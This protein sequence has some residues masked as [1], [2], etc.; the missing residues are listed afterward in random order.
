MFQSIFCLTMALFFLAGCQ[1]KPEK[2][3]GPPGTT[4][5]R[6]GE[7][8][9]DNAA[10]KPA[11][12]AARGAVGKP[13]AVKIEVEV[14][15][16]LDGK[17]EA[18]AKVAA[19]GNELGKTDEKGYLL[20][21]LQKRP[22][23]EIEIVV[24]KEAPGL[25]VTPWK[26]SFV[27]KIPTGPQA[28]RYSFKAALSANRYVTLVVTEKGKPVGDSVVTVK[29]KKV[30]TTDASGEF[31]Y[32][33]KEVPKEGLAFS[34]GKPG[35]ASSI[36]TERKPTPGQK[37][38][39]ALSKRVVVALSCLTEEYGRQRG[40]GDISV[41]VDGATVGK[42]D[43]KGAYIY[44]YDGKPGK[45]VRI[46]LSAP[47]HIP[48]EWET[49]VTLQGEV[50]IQRFFYPAAPQ[51]I[52][53]SIVGFVG[54]TPGADLTNVVKGVEEAVTAQLFKNPAFR[55][56]PAGS[57]QSGMKRA[58]L[59]VEKM[60]TKGWQKTPLEST[61]DMIVLGSVAKEEK[62]F[63]IET[64]FYAATGRPVLSLIENLKEGG[65]ITAAA[66]EIVG[67]AMERFPFEGTVVAAEEDRYR[68]NLGKSGHRIVKGNEF[69]MAAPVADK[70]GRI[71]GFRTVGIVKVQKV[72]DAGS[73]TAAEDLKAGEKIS[74]GDRAVRLLPF[75][76]AGNALVLSAKGGVLPD[77]APLSGV[78]IY[79]NGEWAGST[80]ADGKATAPLRP[81]KNYT[82]MLYKHGYRQVV[83]KVRVETV[84][85]TKE[86]VLA[87]NNAL[88]K[89]DSAP[90]GADVS[91][92]GVSIGKTPLDSGKLVPLG[93]HTVKVSAGEEYRDY[94]VVMEF[95]RDV[96]DR[97][98]NRKIVLFKDYL[99]IGERAAKAGNLD[100]AI[101]A[102]GVATKEH[103]DYSEAHGRLAQIYLDEKN[104][105][106]SAIREFEDVLGLPQNRELI[107]KQYAVMFA[108]LG[109][110][111]YKKGSQLANR[112]KEAAAQS[113]T[114]AIRNLQ[115]ARQNR[116][117]FPAA[118]YDEAVHDTFYYT[119]LSHHKLYLLTKKGA[120][121]DSANNAWREY[122]DFYPAKLVGNS[123]F[124][125]SRQA[126]K[127]YWDQIRDKM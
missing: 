18:G 25:I 81:G 15:A 115:I 49:L 125:K 72:D 54:N 74:V 29:G 5:E 85:E 62:G 34:V 109:N 60:T 21:G 83:E 75:E 116:R 27:V 8:S 127:Q 59:S 9:A 40:V 117:F 96:E 111:C 77:V 100:A 22:G 101:Q 67:N 17:P 4:V 82:L 88:F 124:E 87:V 41:S 13:E 106:D 23:E 103:P 31:V 39:V 78:N 92:D 46:S 10:G 30:G 94:E 69:D 24:E 98:G 37:I 76:G 56:V 118:R 107:H 108:N 6:K 51:P 50:R 95:S 71:K 28:D 99:K 11:D 114:K 126:A 97:T 33:Y 119:A 14:L 102:Y 64:K 93:F 12:N 53:T 7:P 38:G 45:Q 57:I 2:A 16:T 52:R 63:L 36:R 26:G 84:G 123:A 48:K 86:F 112:D 58:K 47:A 79:L 43:D 55:E 89:V 68:I 20:A 44:I 120:L 32:E 42:T 1:G 35:F 91:V 70:S 90:S 113:F 61:V 3:A 80:G 121:L 65:D 105:Y 66:R 122:F 19:A 110:A 104:D 73:W